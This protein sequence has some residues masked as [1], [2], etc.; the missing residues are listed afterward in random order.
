[1]SPM[2][3]QKLAFHIFPPWSQI[4]RS[5]LFCTCHLVSLTAVTYRPSHGRWLAPG[6]S[7]VGAGSG[8]RRRGQT[9]GTWT[10]SGAAVQEEELSGGG[11]GDRQWR[12][13]SRRR[14]GGRRRSRQWGRERP[15][16]PSPAL[17]HGR[18]G[19]Q[20]PGLAIPPHLPTPFPAPAG[21]LKRKP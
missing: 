3:W 8:D 12:T 6:W 19:E 9:A 15:L 1:M 7:G 21:C 11:R 10:G 14:E 4:T 17:A 20:E 5:M 13:G 18:W 2:T 16:I